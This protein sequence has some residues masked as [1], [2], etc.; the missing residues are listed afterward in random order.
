MPNHPADD[1]WMS[2][3]L[4][5]GRRGLGR[6]W[7]NPAVGCVIIKD[8]RVIGRG[9][10]QAGG[11]PHGETRA[12]AQAGGNAVGATAYVTLEPCA[13][14]GQ[15]PPCATALIA[16]G[17]TR[18]V[19]ALEDPDPRVSGGGHAMLRAAGVAVV[20]GVGAA[21]AA[22]DHA[23]FLLTKTQTRPF[24]TLKLAASFDGRIATNSGESQWI[25]GPQARH[26]SHYLRVT[27]DAVMIGSGT[28]R[29]DDPVLTVRGFGDI[30]Q[31]V[32]VIC[33]SNLGTD[34]GGNLGRSA[35]DVPVWLCHGPKAAAANRAA[36]EATGATLIPCKTDA[37]G[38]LDISD[39]LSQLAH[40]GLTRVFCE[41]GGQLAASLLAAGQV[42]QL[43]S[44]NA[45][46]ALG[47]QGTPSVATLPDMPLADYPRFTLRET[48]KIG[49]DALQIW[50][51]S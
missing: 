30:H 42:D 40:R 14:H 8:G 25:T 4:T 38:R 2:L 17:I 19:S 37:N 51:R 9:W 36:W 33:D 31:P 50:R 34:P 13:H 48:R 23:G 35:R 22:F 32:R 16:A 39:A 24:L 15:T 10:T 28:V 11:R 49:V 3:A 21:E 47:A 12:L 5:L 27:H 29:A 45:G 46:L 18:V 41:G 7:P 26:F 20:V 44:F 6:C 1:R 43:I